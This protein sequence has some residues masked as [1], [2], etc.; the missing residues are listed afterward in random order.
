M[1]PELECALGAIVRLVRLAG[2]G[3][4]PEALGIEGLF[5]NGPLGC[6]HRAVHRR[7]NSAFGLAVML[8][9]AAAVGWRFH[10][11]LPHALRH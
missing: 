3:T 8:A 1:Q 9:T 10:G 4:D 11:G 6:G 7:L 5:Q 2:H